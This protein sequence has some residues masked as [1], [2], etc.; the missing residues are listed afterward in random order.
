ML[1]NRYPNADVLSQR[2]HWDE[3][4]RKIVL[5]RVYNVPEFK[6]FSGRARA[7]L[8]ALCDHVIPQQHLPPDRRVPLAPWIDDVSEL[9]VEAFRFE[10]MPPNNVAWEWGLEGIEQTAQ[11]LLGTS[12]VD[13]DREQ[14]TTILERIRVGSPP[15]D[16]WQRM[17]A[18]RW[19]EIIAVRQIAGVYY[20][21]PNAWDEIGFGGPAYPR[22]YLSLNHGDREPWESE[23]VR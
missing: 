5:D 19:W 14:Q 11:L 10:D 13:L 8:E 22:G 20:S 6:H 1:R 7:T 23:E 21:H 9:R 3:A 17:P 12:F 18:S 2:G 16:V 15:G 4:T